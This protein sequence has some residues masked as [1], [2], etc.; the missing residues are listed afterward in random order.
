MKKRDF[1]MM[2]ENQWNVPNGDPFTGEQ[3]YDNYSEKILVSDLRIKRFIR[4]MIGELSGKPVYYLYDSIKA[5]KVSEKMTGSAFAF[6]QYLLDKGT[7]KS[8]DGC[9]LEKGTDLEALLKEFIDVRLFGGILTETGNNATVEGAVQFK[10][11]NSSYNKCNLEVFQNT[12][13]FPSEIKNEQGSIGTSSL[14]PYALVGIEGWLNERTAQ[15]N[16]LTEDD[17]DLML[18]TMWLSI[19]D[20]N[21][22]SKSGQKPLLLLEVIYS[23]KPYKFNSDIEVYQSVKDI[24]SLITLQSDIDEKDIRS[25]SDYTLNFEKLFTECS[26]DNVDTVNFFTE[27]NNLRDL[28]SSNSKFKFKELF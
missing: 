10:N 14:V 17:I 13:V 22:R 19:K 4:D 9:K 2:Y 8:I 26:K 15:I 5:S 6:R 24:K 27:D 7:I 21:S 28:L 1:L 25:Y 3:R 12:S 18:S 23:G 20:K 16:G 11:L